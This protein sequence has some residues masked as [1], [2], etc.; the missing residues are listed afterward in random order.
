M[1]MSIKQNLY[2]AYT[3]CHSSQFLQ[4]TNA[5][6]VAKVLTVIKS[7]T[8]AVTTGFTRDAQKSKEG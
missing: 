1:S 5:L 3:I 7:F 2:A 6:F 8:K 4:N